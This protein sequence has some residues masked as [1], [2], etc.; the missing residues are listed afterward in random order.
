MEEEPKKRY[1]YPARSFLSEN[2]PPFRPIAEESAI[3]LC[4]EIPL[5]K[6]STPLRICLQGA[7]DVRNVLFSVYKRRKLGDNRNIEIIVNDADASII[8]KDILLLALA[9]KTPLHG[10][11]TAL[12]NF[13]N[14]YVALW[15][16]LLISPTHRD[17]LSDL[18]DEYLTTFPDVKFL[19]QDN[20][21]NVKGTWSLWKEDKDIF[22]DTMTAR[23]QM[24]RWDRSQ[25]YYKE[26]WVLRKDAY[27]SD[28]D[29]KIIAEGRLRMEACSMRD[30]A[31]TPHMREEMLEYLRTGTRLRPG[32]EDSTMPEH[33]R[34]NP[35][36][37]DSISR[38]YPY[39]KCNPFFALL[40]AAE[41]VDFCIDDQTMYCTLNMTMQRLLVV[42]AKELVSGRVSLTFDIGD[43]ETLIVDRLPPD[44]AFDVIDT[45]SLSDVKGILPLLLLNSPRLNRSEP[46]S[47][48]WIQSLRAHR[49]SNSIDNYLKDTLPVPYSVWPTLFQV[50]CSLPFESGLAFNEQRGYK[51]MPD[52]YTQLIMKWKAASPRSMT[53]DLVPGTVD[54][55][56]KKMID[57]MITSIFW[58][59]TGRT[60]IIRINNIVHPMYYLTISALMHLLLSLAHM[61]TRPKELFSHFYNKVQAMNPKTRVR[62]GK[63]DFGAFALDVQTTAKCICPPEFQPDQP[64]HHF[65]D[66]EE[67]EVETYFFR[68]RDNGEEKGQLSP[69]GFVLVEDLTLA[70]LAALEGGNCTMTSFG[71]THEWL[72]TN[73]HRIQIIDNAVV[74]PESRMMRLTLPK[75]SIAKA[76]FHVIGMDL[77]KGTMIFTPVKELELSQSC[78]YPKT[79]QIP[80]CLYCITNCQ[81]QNSL[82]AVTALYEYSDRYEVHIVSEQP[83]SPETQLHFVQ[84][85]KT[86]LRMSI[87]ASESPRGT[88]HKRKKKR[89]ENEDSVTSVTREINFPGV[90]DAT[91]CQSLIIGENSAILVAPKA[92]E[93]DSPVKETL[94]LDNLHRWPL[95][96]AVGMGHSLYTMIESQ[97]SR[98]APRGLGYGHDW[99]VDVRQ[100]ISAMYQSFIDMNA[101]DLRRVVKLKQDGHMIF[102]FVSSFAKGFA[103]YCPSLLVTPR[104]TPIIEVYYGIFTRPLSKECERLILHIE[105]IP[106]KWI[107]D[108]RGL[109]EEMEFLFSFLDQNNRLLTNP[110][111]RLMAGMKMK[112]SFIYPLYPLEDRLGHKVPIPQNSYPPEL[113]RMAL[114]EKEKGTDPKKLAAAGQILLKQR[115]GTMD[116][117]LFDISA[118]LRALKA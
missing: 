116:G 85:E 6:T 3:D 24:N 4:E 38:K 90:V 88:L 7:G 103:A 17:Q 117:W 67:C 80:S 79:K 73:S 20:Q 50:T 104:G 15:A 95:N 68:L 96:R 93:S 97:T 25:P 82:F 111:P 115:P 27:L 91:N 78:H 26:D 2:S 55:I 112:R 41:E 5:R 86:C 102:H 83:L 18:L 52:T 34:V 64:L 32:R 37:I 49:A 8:A 61:L 14:F 46:H 48:L 57:D 87:T 56:F 43:C 44:M 28:R 101:M 58:V 40:T 21:W 51:S 59:F 54:C 94:D 84:A 12:T 63:I 60:R 114:E 110:E 106:K 75:S 31:P 76:R 29:I 70:D 22:V 33:V 100:T 72:F 71:P 109:D 35:T 107:H 74:D 69:L 30:F 53:I 66:Q 89:K 1:V 92:T 113:I 99:Y 10:D 105:N 45:A 13:T 23:E 65:Y 62:F 9:G 98:S 36:V 108:T 42:F 77:L 81:R 11:K 39:Y 16:D 47:T 19:N 118:K